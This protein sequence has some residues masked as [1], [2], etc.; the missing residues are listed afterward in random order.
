[1]KGLTARVDTPWVAFTPLAAHTLASAQQVAFGADGPF[2]AA[3]VGV[4]GSGK[5]TLLFAILREALERGALPVWEEAAAFIERLAPPGET[6]LPQVFVARVRQW[7]GQLGQDSAER[8]AYLTDLH[9][10]GRG[11][12]AEKLSQGQGAQPQ[13]AVGPSGFTPVVLLIDEVEQAHQLL[14]KRI[15]TDDGQ[16]LRALVDACGPELRLLLAYAP[17]SY[18]ALGDADR[19]RLVTLPVPSIDVPAIQ[20]HF[21]LTRGQ[22]NFAWWISRGRARGVEQAVRGVLEPL[23]AGLFAADLDALGD[24]MDALPG[25]FGVPAL[26]RHGLDHRR[27]N[28]LADLQPGPN[29]TPCGGVTILVSDRRG[30]ADRIRHELERRW[31]PS[32][33]LQPVANELV[34]VIEACADSD[35]RAYLT[36]DDFAAAL[37]VAEARAVE[38]GRIREPLERLTQEGARIFDALGEMGPLPKRLP[39]A[40]R[41]LADELFPSP[42]TDPYLPLDDGRVPQEAELERRLREL[43]PVAGPLLHSESAGFSVFAHAEKLAQ[44]IAAGALDGAA[45]PLRVLL[46]DPSGPRPAILDL[47]EFAGRLAVVDPGRFHATFLKCLAVRCHAA[48][49]GARMDAM[50]D[51]QRGD[52]QLARKIA[53]HRDRVAVQ[54]RDVRPRPTPRWQAAVGYIRQQDSFRGT[55]ARLDRDSPALLGLLFALRPI[56][57]PEKVLSA[58]AAALF[59]E[60]NPLR[61]LARE[62]NPGG[63][64]SGAAVVIDSLLPAATRTPRWT[65]QPSPAAAELNAVLDRFAADAELRPRLA[66]WLYTEDRQRLEALLQHHA[67]TLPDVSREMDALEALRRLDDTARQAVAIVGDLERCTGRRQAGLSA[68]RLGNFTDSVRTQAGPVE[69]LRL[70]T[71]ELQGLG[72]RSAQPWVAALLLWICGVMAARLLKGLEKEQASLAEWQRLAAVGADLGRQADELQHSLTQLGAQRCVDLL[73]HRRSQIANQLD[74]LPT[75]AREIEHLRAA[76]ALLQPLTAA[77]E[78]ACEALQER[79]ISIAEALE[80]YLPDLDAASTELGLL[81]KLPELIVE[82]ADEAPRPAGRGL[83]EY[84]EALRKHAEAS[85]R[86]RL[87]M[88]L[89]NLL[90][91]DLA[92][93]LRVDPGDV[94][95]I[96]AAW[97]ALE[98][99]IRQPLTV[100]LQAAAPRGTDEI[101]RWLADAAVKAQLLATWP[102]AQLPALAQVDLRVAAWSQAL[103]TTPDD[104]REAAR[105]RQRAQGSLQNLGSS[106]LPA[107]VLDEL[108]RT[109]QG[110]EGPRAYQAILQA[111][112]EFEERW[113]AL[114]E[115]H[116]KTAGCY[117]TAP[118]AATTPQ[119]ALAELEE[120]C[121]RQAAA[122]E[123]QVAQLREVG[124]VL[125]ELAERP[126]GI[127]HELSLAGAT[128]LLERENA[129]VR[130][131]LVRR[132]EA[133]VNW[134]HSARLPARLAP[135]PKPDL[136]EWR[137]ELAEAWRQVAE[138]EP[139]LETARRLGLAVPQLTDPAWSELATALKILNQTA[140]DE[141][142]ALQRQQ[143]EYAERLLR[144]GGPAL[145]TGPAQLS[146]PE[147][148]QR[149]EHTR[150]QVDQ[151]RQERLRGASATAQQF[152]AAV[153]AG[154]TGGLPPGIEELVALGLLRT[155]EEPK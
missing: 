126:L 114:K 66:A 150:A 103:Q 55:L 93:E 29:P 94:K 129:R 31:N 105:M 108:I 123:A 155:I 11:D 115:R 136:N 36:L 109:S 87:R 39:F 111:A 45:D 68:L 43:W 141:L 153:L 88:H 112:R 85:R 3:A 152:Y 48:G 23:K 89:E 46:L 113:L 119:D 101:Q 70:L 80:A 72:E 13:K 124:A 102:E 98:P 76:V 95:A 15:A 12:V 144:L 38:S 67:G 65:E 154:D 52:R 21:G 2:A 133:L 63:R 104:L 106:L 42:F 149:L 83:I 81:R 32:E 71:A 14:L 151:Q 18:H 10:R 96:D 130:E 78:Q 8:R 100:A 79:G 6:L 53:W 37:R 140:A 135:A 137:G 28:Q 139:H 44:H 107:A 24:A 75:A 142:T 35:D 49:L 64:L 17:E 1:M 147:V 20:G 47:A 19:G 33:E 127:P 128:R 90:G 25:V 58:K 4:Y 99:A 59:A 92:S 69:Q 118:L 131:A 51:G 110:A 146:L 34:A 22:A 62:A 91:T 117:P 30:L 148:R 40:V 57:P 97:A 145:R 7:L 125:S 121:N 120:L 86:Q 56:S 84:L 134:L 50:L 9:Q 138:L 74:I 61:R 82:L 26:L 60:G 122:L 27:L 77:L 5:S 41:E 116:A 73:R 143:D 132:Q 16:P 54:V